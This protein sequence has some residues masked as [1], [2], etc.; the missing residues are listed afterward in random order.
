[1]VMKGERLLKG[2]FEPWVGQV[3]ILT[4]HGPL[5]RIAAAPEEGNRENF[6]IGEI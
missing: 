5:N 3:E 6:N 1:M 2:S 4:L